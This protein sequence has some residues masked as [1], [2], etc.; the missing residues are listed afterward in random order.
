MRTAPGGGDAVFQRVTISAK[1]FGIAVGLVLIGALVAAIS[2]HMTDVVSAQLR[3]VTDNYMPAYAALSDAD[4]AVGDE[5]LL[6]GRLFPDSNVDLAAPEERARIVA[7]VAEKEKQ[8]DGAITEA[9]RLINRQIEDPFAFDDDVAL[10]R[11]DERL[12]F[13]QND[14]NAYRT[15]LSALLDAVAANRREQVLA[16][17]PQIES[18]RARSSTPS[19]TPTGPRCSACPR[20]RRRRRAPTSRAR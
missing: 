11:L 16:L 2:A 18:Y 13:L 3:I 1:I 9:R 20:P 12:A 7:G 4:G 14:R 19:S 17:M 8:V 6:L 10:A 15:G 5:S